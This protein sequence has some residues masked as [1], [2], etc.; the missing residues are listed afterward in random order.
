MTNNNNNKT[1]PPPPPKKRE[2]YLHALNFY[3]K[4]Y[5]CF[6]PLV[7]AQ[8]EERDGRKAV[9]ASGGTRFSQYEP[10]EQWIDRRERIRKQSSYGYL[11]SW[12][13][14]SMIVKAGDDCRQELMAVQLI[15]QVISRLY[16][17]QLKHIQYVTRAW[18]WFDC[19]QGV[20]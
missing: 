6:S 19:Q 20:S 17:R 15:R 12:D 3:L 2:L 10:D 11:E 8:R 5:N 13:V 7:V 14:H 16:L 9:E 1:P 18:L 4:I